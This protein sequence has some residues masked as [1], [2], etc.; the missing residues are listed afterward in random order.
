MHKQQ[1][2]CRTFVRLEASPQSV[3]LF[4]GHMSY[5]L[6]LISENLP[7]RYHI[8][9]INQQ[10]VDPKIQDT[11]VWSIFY[12]KKVED[13]IEETLRWVRGINV[14]LQAVSLHDILYSHLRQ[15]SVCASQQKMHRRCA[16]ANADNP[17]ATTETKP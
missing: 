16:E 8:R 13:V 12:E 5:Q 10:V 4:V 7:H 1:K 3:S 11:K 17:F 9:D 6:G 14:D 2:S 15:K